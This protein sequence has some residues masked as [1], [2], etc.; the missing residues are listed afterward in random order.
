M[1]QLARF[2]EGSQERA[3][4]AE[5]PP[6]TPVCCVVRRSTSGPGELVV[7]CTHLLY[8]PRRHDVKLAQVALLLAE[9]D[10]LAWCGRQLTYLPVLLAGDLNLQPFTPV[11]GSVGR[12]GTVSAAFH[13]ST[14]H[15]EGVCICSRSRRYGTRCGAVTVTNC[16]CGHQ[17]YSI[18]E[19][20]L[21]S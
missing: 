17:M 2:A 3:P 1:T 10:R 20:A 16:V 11:R 8:N 14:G 15:G 12:E 6:V 18:A 19:L 4:E 9:L 7:A 21:Y 5:S 13:T